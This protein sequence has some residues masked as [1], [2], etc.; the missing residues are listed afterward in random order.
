[1]QELRI[2]TPFVIMVCLTACATSHV[3]IG[4]ARPPLAPDQ[5]QIYFKPPTA[6]YEQI[7]QLDTSSKGSFSFSAQA[8]TD[9]V[10]ARLKVEAAKLGANG[11]LIQSMGDRPG[12]EVSTGFGQSRFSG[13]GAF[14]GG[15]GF[16]G[17]TTLKAA[18]GIAIYV[19]PP[20]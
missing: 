20:R 8:K 1:M 17:T 6:K 16:S 11:V 5:V 18:S 15:V 2:I 14:G 3:M 10:I 12:A 4:K 9:A 7:A 19:E 13:N